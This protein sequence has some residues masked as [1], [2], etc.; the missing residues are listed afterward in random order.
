MLSIQ[1]V[2]TINFVMW[3]TVNSFLRNCWRQEAFL[4]SVD[5]DQTAQNVQSD[6]WSILSSFSFY[7]NTE[8]VLHLAMKMYF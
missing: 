3:Q 7:N 4:D 1:S 5:Q 6:L 2:Y 8:L